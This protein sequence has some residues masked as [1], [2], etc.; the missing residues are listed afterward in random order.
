[1]RRSRRDH[2]RPQRPRAR[3]SGKAASL[4]H[5]DLATAA[6]AGYAGGSS[7]IYVPVS[8]AGTTRAAVLAAT[9]PPSRARRPAGSRRPYATT[10]E[11]PSHDRSPRRGLPAGPDRGD[12]ASRGRRSTGA[13]PLGSGPLVRA[14]APLDRARLVP[15]KRVRRGRPLRVPVLA[16]HWAGAVPRRGR[17]S[18]APAT[19]SASS[20]TSRT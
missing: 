5:I 19:S 16:R 6:A 17:T 7:R 15:P 13:R 8:E 9:R 4:W 1:M 2:R 3:V 18:C 12:H 10:L 14:G 20:S 11:G